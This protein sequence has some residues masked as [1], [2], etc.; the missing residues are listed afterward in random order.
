MTSIELY[1]RLAALGF[2]ETSEPAAN[3]NQQT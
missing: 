2:N 3:I 1:K